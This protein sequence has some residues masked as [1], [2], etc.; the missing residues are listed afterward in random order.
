M[1]ELVGT[2]TLREKLQ[3]IPPGS[4]S[5]SSYGKAN[6]SRARSLGLTGNYLISGTSAKIMNPSDWVIKENQENISSL[7]IKVT[8][9]ISNDLIKRYKKIALQRVRVERLDDGT[10][11]A[12]L[13]GFPGVWANDEKSEKNALKALDEVLEDWIVIK[14]EMN[15]GD[16]PIIDG[17]DLN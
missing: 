16:I 3:N 7:E 9:H 4:W 14:I 6:V 8:K 15:D 13:I 2:C 5:G 11:Y 1:P 12:E 17:I 10:W